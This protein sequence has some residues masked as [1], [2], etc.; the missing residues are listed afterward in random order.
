[1]SRN[2]PSALDRLLPRWH[3]REVHR[4][5]V[6]LPP[7]PVMAAVHATTWGEAPLARALMAV[8]G[9][10]V[11]AGRR[12]VEDSLGAMGE[13]VPAGEDEFL[14]VGVDTMDEGRPR[15][16]GG[17][18]DL[19]AHHHGPGLLKIGMNVRYAGGV[20]S[21]ETRILATDEATRRRFLRYWLVV[22]CGSGL[23]RRSML[24]AI[25]ARARRAAAPR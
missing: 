22:R 23:T 8:T 18:A 13:V 5:P 24:R 3:F 4:L 9:A 19:V 16:E 25:R 15:P 21:T 10:D 17:T 1:M 6:H 7:E 12:I 11:A 2:P 14:F 20:L